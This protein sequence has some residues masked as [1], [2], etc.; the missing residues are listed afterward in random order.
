MATI[1]ANNALTLSELAHRKDPSGNLAAIAEVLAEDSPVLQSAMW[2]EANDTFSHK[3]VRR[4]SLPSGSWRKLNEGVAV[5]ASQTEEFTEGIGILQ[6]YSQVD[7]DLADAAPNK[8]QFLMDEAR[9]FLEGLSQTFENIFFYGNSNTA[10]ETFSGLST[11]MDALAATQNVIGAGGTGSDTTSIYGVQWGMGST[12]MV[13]PKGSSVGLTHTH[14]GED[15]LSDSSGNLYQ[16]YRD[17]FS[18]KGGLVVKEPRSIIRLA[19]IESSGTS[20]IFDEDD[21]ITLLNRMRQSGAG[22]VLYCNAT[23]KTQMEIAL[24]DKTNV[25]Y[26][27]DMGEGLAGVPMLRFR[28][29]PIMKSDAIT[30]TETA[31]S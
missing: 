31:I 16:G 25:N 22:T 21:L 2:T 26:T 4:A 13:Y 7:K 19:N 30:I 12:H 3:V 23:I 29:N 9:S 27:A 5:E 17:L 10:P 15:T 1:T 14:L 18:M 11:R 24:K 20:N 8:A 28:G 6:T